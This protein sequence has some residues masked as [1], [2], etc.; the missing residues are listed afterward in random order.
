[1]EQVRK[2]VQ[3]LFVVMCSLNQIVHLI[4]SV[5]FLLCNLLS[6]YQRA[7]CMYVLLWS[8]TTCIFQLSVLWLGVLILCV[9]S[10]NVVAPA[11]PRP[12]VS[13]RS[14]P[15]TF[16]FQPSSP[17]CNNLITATVFSEKC[18]SIEINENWKKKNGDFFWQN[19]CL[20]RCC[21]TLSICGLA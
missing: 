8:F 1:M 7:P 2:G 18:F 21:V 11:I 16:L 15:G 6:L 12:P 14:R 19:D 9:I 10:L 17:T 3:C 20:E 13:L 4:S 5:L